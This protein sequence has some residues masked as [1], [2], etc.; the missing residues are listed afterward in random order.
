MSHRNVAVVRG[1]YE[2]W[3]QGDFS[4]GIEVFDPLAV[5]VMRPEFPDA[6]TYLGIDRIRDYTRGFLE[7]WTRLT[8]EA[9]EVIEAGDSVVVAVRQSGTGSESGVATELSYFHLWSLRGGKAIRLETVR[10]RDDAL[11]AVGLLD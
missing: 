8:I 4:A 5:L 9:E 1:V 6:G 3:S 10:E 11:R 7:P 2:G